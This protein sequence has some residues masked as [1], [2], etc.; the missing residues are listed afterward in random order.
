MVVLEDEC[1]TK[2]MAID[3]SNDS[4]RENE[5][6][7]VGEFNISYGRHSLM[8]LVKAIHVFVL[9]PLLHTILSTRI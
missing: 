1:S 7:Q 8:S 6:K 2:C 9:N 5:I 3:R 4:V